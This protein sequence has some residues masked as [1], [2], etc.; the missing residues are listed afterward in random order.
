MKKILLVLCFVFITSCAY[1]DFFVYYDKSTDEIQFIVEQERKLHLSDEDKDRLKKKKMSGRIRD[2]DLIEAYTD[3]KLI[4]NHFVVNTQKISD[5][6]NAAIAEEAKQV[7][8][9]LDQ[10]AAKV[11]LMSPEWMPLTE[12]EFNSLIN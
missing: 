8:K 11:K 9:L 12:A 1:A 2:Y 5:R 3:Y 6:I 4:G 10:E 7:Q